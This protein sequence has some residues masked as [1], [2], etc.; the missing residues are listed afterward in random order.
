M[1]NQATTEMVGNI[2]SIFPL[3]AKK[4]IKPYHFSLP[5]SLPLS[6]TQVLFALREI[7][8]LPVS[9]IAR[10]LEISRPNM[11]PIINNLIG[12]GLAE[13]QSDP[14]DHRVSHISL[15]PAGLEFIRQLQDG[16]AQHLEKE[17]QHLKESDLQ[18]LAEALL[19]IKRV[20]G[21]LPGETLPRPPERE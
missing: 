21:K 17:L 6:H 3:L 8:S 2:L 16:M 12:K 1:K 4:L 20:I 18:A 15:T 9:E 5:G 7:G 19:T 14:D 13:R 11:T 10:G